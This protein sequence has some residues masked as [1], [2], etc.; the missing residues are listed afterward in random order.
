M[1]LEFGTTK[2]SDDG[3]MPLSLQFS[4]WVKI[5]RVTQSGKFVNML[6]VGPDEYM[7]GRTYTATS[8][9]VSM[10]QCLDE[11]TAGFHC[12]TSVEMACMFATET[13]S[14]YYDLAVIPVRPQGILAYGSQYGVP[15]GVFST[16]TLGDTVII[17]GEAL[18]SLLRIYRLNRVNWSNSKRHSRRGDAPDPAALQRDIARVRAKNALIRLPVWVEMFE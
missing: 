6:Q 14:P 18:E 1:C 9:T 10:E 17:Q 4:N 16:I 2:I 8:S 3:Y 11:Y 15:V 5:F 12:L 7:L 13:V